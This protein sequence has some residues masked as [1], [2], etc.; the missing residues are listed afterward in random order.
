LD[1]PV[2]APDA[3]QALNPSGLVIM[4][5]PFVLLFGLLAHLATVMIWMPGLTALLDLEVYRAGGSAVLSGAALY[6]GTIIDGLRFTYPPFSAVMFTPLAVIPAGMLKLLF[7]AVNVAAL[8]LSIWLCWRALHYRA[9]S[10]AAM[11]S[12][13]L[14]GL[15]FWLEPVR[16]TIGIGQINLLL[17][18]VVLWDLGR[19][20]SARWKGSGSASRPESS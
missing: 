1:L 3:E 20:D 6:D 10:A 15:L 12:V 4:L 7:T 9:D 8:G 16:S 18:L 2:R 5:A 11:V 14:T 19:P 13:L 17:M